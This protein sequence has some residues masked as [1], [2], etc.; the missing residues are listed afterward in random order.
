MS[1]LATECAYCACLLAYLTV[2]TTK[3]RHNDTLLM[4][5]FVH[6]CCFIDFFMLGNLA[7]RKTH[8]FIGKSLF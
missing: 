8:Y 5:T 6:Y 7:L 3:L 4:T 1:C 2:A